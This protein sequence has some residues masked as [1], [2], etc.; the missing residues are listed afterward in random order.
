MQELIKDARSG[1]DLAWNSLYQQHYPWLYATALRICGNTPV[2]KDILQDTFIQAHLKLHQLKDPTAFAG[3]LKSILINYCRRSMKCNLVYSDGST[4]LV[5]ND[6]ISEDEIDRKL[7]MYERQTRLHNVFIGLSDT[8]QSVLLLRY[9][10]EW[11]S[12]DQIATI[13]CI[14]VGTVRSRLNQAKQK[15]TEHW[16]KVDSDNDVAY[17]E[18][19]EWNYLYNLYFGSMHSCLTSREKFLQHMDA[20]LQV[21]F[22]SGKSAFGRDV[23]EKEIDEDLI[24]GNRFKEISVMSTKQLSI[25]EVYN[26]NSSEYP[27]RCPDSSILVLFRDKNKI[28]RMNL[29]NSH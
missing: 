10:S 25:V 4:S 8:L 26:T 14:P 5:D 13:L 24:Y 7:D 3:W 9:F 15:I 2:V 29:H 20:N 11:R 19:E 27:G 16:P 22:T 21:V 6:D 12:Y 18:A 28:T 23:I 1:N 17:R